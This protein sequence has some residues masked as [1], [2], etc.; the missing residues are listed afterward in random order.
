MALQTT[1]PNPGTPI[2]YLNIFS[3][4][5]FGASI[6]TLTDSTLMVVDVVDSH[7]LGLAPGDILLGHEGVPWKELTPELYYSG[8]PLG[9]WLGSNESA[10][11]YILLTNMGNNWHLFG[12]MD[13]IKYGTED[14]LNLSLES[15][16]SFNTDE[17]IFN[18]PQIPVAGVP[19]P[20]FDPAH[21]YG[22]VSHGTVEGTNT[23]YIYV[24]KHNYYDLDPE[25]NTAVTELK[26]TD[27]LIIDLRWNT[28]GFRQL[29]LGISQLFNFDFQPMK[30]L[31]RCNPS[32]LKNLCLSN[33]PN[34]FDLKADPNTYYE[35]PIAILVG[36][37]TESFG[38]VIA[39]TLKHHP[40]A[41][42]FGR[43]TNGA[44]S[45][46]YN[47][48]QIEGWYVNAPDFTQ[49]DKTT[50]FEP[51]V[52]N[53]LK[54]HEEVW[55]TQDDVANGEDTVV[56]RAL[57]WMKTVAYA[58]D[59]FTDKTFV[60]SGDS[61]RI[62]AV[63]ENP[64]GNELQVRAFIKTGSEYLDTLALFDDGTHG[65]LQAGDDIFS[66]KAAVP[67]MAGIFT[68]DIHTESQM[69]Q[70]IKLLPNMARF[71]T[72]GPVVLSEVKYTSTD[73]VANYNDRLFFRMKLSNKGSSGT[74]ENLFLS[75]A[76][77]DSALKVD[78]RESAINDIDPGLG[79]WS[80]GVFWF[81]VLSDS[82]MTSRVYV[83]IKSES[84]V[85]WQD[86]FYV[87]ILSGL[88]NRSV[89]MPTAFSLEQNYPNPFN[90]VT[91]IGFQI[92]KTANVTLK[93]FNMLGKEVATLV[94]D[95]LNPGSY[96]Y[97]FDGS[98]LASGVYYYRLNTNQGLVQTRKF[99]LIK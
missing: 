57:E 81:K 17:I 22:G 10:I 67:E 23:G 69:A 33:T 95:R 74:A 24:S 35:R 14:T 92:P 31:W 44:F 94:A 32:Q 91:H 34:W 58:R 65:D 50:S 88:E 75:L 64:H 93:I 43:E 27:G 4:D 51:L 63:L 68:I 16:A 1:P 47:R 83:N 18:N 42:L 21:E 25:F 26:D 6:T 13:V 41:R 72:I 86:S 3:A 59:V 85:L 48:P 15:M 55:L 70:T 8:I 78:S 73:T 39:Y 80:D 76:S 89:E 20:D 29:F 60:Q 37:N 87:D 79:M 46:T 45:G 40:S 9:G 53:A 77:A 54:P 19:L 96:R 12:S 28:G 82:V 90:P 98:N 84:S 36:P 30:M 49:A 66:G 97:S 71:T 62:S 38:D 56:K 5:H 52:R 7:P 2:Y 11:S 99:M 61:I